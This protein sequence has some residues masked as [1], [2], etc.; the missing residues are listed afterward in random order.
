MTG[1]RKFDIIIK[2]TQN[3]DFHLPKHPA[4]LSFFYVGDIISDDFFSN[5][6]IYFV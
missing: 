2:L 1:Y 6:Y 4:H 5:S 3:R